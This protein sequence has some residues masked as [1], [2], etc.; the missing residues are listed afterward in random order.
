MFN[1]KKCLYTEFLFT[2]NNISY[3]AVLNEIKYL[4]KKG[5]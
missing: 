4:I 2:G 1:V 3:Y 5:F